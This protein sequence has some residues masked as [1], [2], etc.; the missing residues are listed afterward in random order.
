[1]LITKACEQ[2]KKWEEQILW[3]ESSEYIWDKNFTVRIPLS[4]EQFFL[5]SLYEQIKHI[6]N[7]FSING[8]NISLEISD[9]ALLSQPL[10]T[11]QILQRL[12]QLNIQLSINNFSTNYFELNQEHQF[13]FNNLII[14]S[15]F[16]QDNKELIQNIITQVH[17]HNMTLTVANITQQQQ[18]DYLYEIGCDFGQGDLLT[19]KLAPEL[20]PYF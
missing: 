2:I 7:E 17:K 13:P 1:M 20:I 18:I 16:L 14:N 11:K 6:A 19:Q 5:P 8:E 15:Y 3:N 12:K 9:A 10:A 4:S